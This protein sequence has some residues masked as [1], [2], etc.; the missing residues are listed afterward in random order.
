MNEAVD[1]EMAY[2][3][4]RYI[5]AIETPG[6]S[7]EK[8]LDWINWAKSKADWLDPIVDKEDAILGKREHN[9]SEDKKQLKHKGYYW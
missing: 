3:I 5:A 8:I 7:D 9:E 1:Y 4:R 6:E 2:K